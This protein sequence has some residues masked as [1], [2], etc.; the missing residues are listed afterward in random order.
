[1]T[2]STLTYLFTDIEGSTSQWETAT[3][4][5]ERVEHHFAILRECVVAGGGE[6]FDT[7]GEGNH[8]A[9]V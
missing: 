6:I 8:D 2:V 7:M 5:S 1:M 9:S 3:D 4:M